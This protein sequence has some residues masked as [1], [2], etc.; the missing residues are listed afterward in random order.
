MDFGILKTAETPRT[1]CTLK[2]QGCQ[3]QKGHSWTLVTAERQQ[4][5]ESRNRKVISHRRD[6]N[7]RR[8]NY[9]DANN[10]GMP[11]ALEKPVME[12]K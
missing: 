6:A 8:G 7:N 1:A 2:Q 12:E 3:Q 9:R 10:R 4:Q 11:T 5:H